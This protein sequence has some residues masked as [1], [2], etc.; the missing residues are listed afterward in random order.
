LNDSGSTLTIS[1]SFHYDTSTNVVSGWDLSISGPSDAPYCTGVA[2]G[3]PCYTFQPET[4]ASG[5][6]SPDQF[7]FVGPDAGGYTD[8]LFIYPGNSSNPLPDATYSIGSNSLLRTVSPGG[9]IGTAD[10]ISGSLS[11][12]TS[13]TS[14]VPE[15]SSLLLL[16]SGLIGGIGVMRRRSR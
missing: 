7:E 13:S 10:F 11:A 12:Q 3:T 5:S 4:G 9:A 8:Y 1:G 16:G 6:F 15:P 14:A 2:T